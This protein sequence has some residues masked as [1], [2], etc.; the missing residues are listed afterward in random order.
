MSGMDD[1]V[2]TI[3]IDGFQNL[4]KE[5]SAMRSDLAAV[6][7]VSEDMKDARHQLRNEMNEHLGMVQVRLL[8]IETEQSEKRGRDRILGWLAS[9]G[10]GTGILGGLYSF[11]KHG[12]PT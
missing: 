3:L 2:K 8:G 11:F 9:T 1:D 5:V 10:A 12:G 4:S 6:K 7:A